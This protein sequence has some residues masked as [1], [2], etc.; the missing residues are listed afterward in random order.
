[1]ARQSKVWKKRDLNK[2]IKPHALDAAAT[3]HHHSTGRPLQ[4]G[5]MPQSEVH[6]QGGFSLS[7]FI[8]G[9]GS[10]EKCYAELK[11]AS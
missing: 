7:Y 11:S 5:P 6:F 3:T 4:E 2:S 1:M 8:Q 10:G 9:L